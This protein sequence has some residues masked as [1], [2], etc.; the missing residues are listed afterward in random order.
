M[1]RVEFVSA[2]DTFDLET[3]KNVKV[4]LRKIN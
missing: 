1:E 3:T 2:F 4:E